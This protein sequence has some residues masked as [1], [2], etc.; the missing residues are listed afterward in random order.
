MTD[1][2][3]AWEQ[4]QEMELKYGTNLGAFLLAFNYV[5]STLYQ[6]VREIL[7]SQ[8]LERFAE[9][10]APRKVDDAIRQLRALNE[11]L[12]PS[13]E[14]NL[15]AAQ[16]LAQFRN[17]VAHGKYQDHV[18]VNFDTHKLE[19]GFEIQS[20]RNRNSTNV[21]IEAL[22]ENTLIAEKLL[23]QLIAVSILLKEASTIES[24]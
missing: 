6:L 21:T 20:T 1:H 9:V 23:N 3:D 24:V 5:E 7:I 8:K 4:M 14:I 2:M 16:Q 13:H 10:C 15:E 11:D 17:R 22:E 12:F 18:R 19:C